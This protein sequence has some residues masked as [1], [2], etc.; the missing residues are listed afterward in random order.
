LYLS[1]R[2]GVQTPLLNTS[3]YFKQKTHEKPEYV[4]IHSDYFFNFHREHKA[5]FDDLKM[6]GI[7][8]TNYWASS[9]IGIF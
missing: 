1:Q 7:I 8:N 3:K 2:G 9:T 6:H 5:Y 4:D